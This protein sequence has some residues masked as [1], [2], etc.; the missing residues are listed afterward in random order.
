LKRLADLV[1]QLWQNTPEAK[2]VNGQ[3]ASVAEFP[4]VVGLLFQGSERP[5]CGGSLIRPNW[6]LT[7]AHCLE[8]IR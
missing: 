2:I 3:T 4:W 7:A 5:G 8:G 6:V 1:D